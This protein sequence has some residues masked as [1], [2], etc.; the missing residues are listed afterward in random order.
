MLIQVNPGFVSTCLNL[1]L[2]I[3]TNCLKSPG[4]PR[5]LA[6]VELTLS[7]SDNIQKLERYLT[8]QFLQEQPY[9]GRLAPYFE[10]PCLRS[11]TP[12]VS[13]LPRTV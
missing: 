7:S 8:R 6:L 3:L 10:R 1:A 4:K 2:L 13:R 5:I 11:G 12:D 9:L